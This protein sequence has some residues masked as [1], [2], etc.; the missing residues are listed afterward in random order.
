[1]IIELRANVVFWSNLYFLAID[2][3]VQIRVNLNWIIAGYLIRENFDFCLLLKL[4]DEIFVPE[5]RD[6][7]NRRA[8]VK[9]SVNAFNSIVENSLIGYFKTIVIA[10]LIFTDLDTLHPAG[11]EEVLVHNDFRSW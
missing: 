10:Y 6:A 7:D 9:D 3:E 2:D 5:Q 11:P 1:M 4:E 8:R